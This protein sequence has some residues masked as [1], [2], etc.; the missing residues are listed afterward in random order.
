MKKLLSLFL[1]LI[2]FFLSSCGI[3]VPPS[4]PPCADGI[5]PHVYDNGKLYADEGKPPYMEYT[6]TACGST[7]TTAVTSDPESTLRLADLLPWCLDLTSETVTSVRYEKGAIGVAPENLSEIKYSNDTADINT[8]LSLLRATLVKI[9]KEQAEIDGGSYSSYTFITETDDYKI[10]FNNG[11]FT[12]NGNSYVFEDLTVSAPKT[13]SVSSHSF[14]DAGDSF[15]VYDGGDLIGNFTGL[16]S[17]EFTEYTGPITLMIPTLYA[18][19]GFGGIL[20]IYNSRI[21]SYSRKGDDTS[22]YYT[23]TSDFDFSFL[24]E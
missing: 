5:T 19:T 14:I 24:F 7:Y 11:I 13:P 12:N 3:S 18:E 20:R 17:L 9:P 1:A 15:T 16:E 23:V 10:S 2:T 6:C 22:A 4:P 21:F 8:A